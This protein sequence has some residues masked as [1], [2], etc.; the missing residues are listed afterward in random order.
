VLYIQAV[1][2]NFLIF[3]I[4]E[5]AEDLIVNDPLDLFGGAPEQFFDVDSKVVGTLGYLEVKMKAARA[6]SFDKS[7]LKRLASGGE[8]QEILAKLGTGSLN[9]ASA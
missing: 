4:Q 8:E 5:D 3:V 1:T 6:L 2:K 7:I 9:S